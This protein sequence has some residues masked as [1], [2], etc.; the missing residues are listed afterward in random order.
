MEQEA[1]TQNASDDDTILDLTSKFRAYTDSLKEELKS[2]QNL[3]KTTSNKE[4]EEYKQ[5]YSSIIYNLTSLRSNHRALYNVFLLKNI[6][7]SFF[8]FFLG[9][10][11]NT[12]KK[13]KRKRIS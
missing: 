5:L 9:N 1:Y 13:S 10:R 7:P 2:L 4:D 8:K 12:Y 6:F 3:R 11:K